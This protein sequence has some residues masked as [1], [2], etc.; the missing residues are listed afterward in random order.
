MLI[1]SAYVLQLLRNDNK[2]DLNLK[3]N[4]L[5]IFIESTDVRF[6]LRAILINN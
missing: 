3:K 1:F 5:N 4:Y 6:Q 2:L